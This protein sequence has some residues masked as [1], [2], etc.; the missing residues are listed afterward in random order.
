MLPGVPHWMYWFT[1]KDR[2]QNMESV[3]HDQVE[4]LP[5]ALR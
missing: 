2:Q 5:E 3:V 1:R 4:R